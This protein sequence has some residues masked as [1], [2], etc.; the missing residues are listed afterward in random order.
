MDEANFQGDGATRGLPQVLT[1]E[2]VA[3]LLRV[4]R[5]TAY[6]VIAEGSV[7][8][9]R[10]VGRSIRISRDAVLEWLSK[11]AGRERPRGRAS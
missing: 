5:K 11:G 3:D 10:R 7:P 2:E 9:V 1:V 6:A 4:D 8:G